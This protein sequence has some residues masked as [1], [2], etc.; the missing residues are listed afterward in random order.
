LSAKISNRIEILL[1]HRDSQRVFAE[2]H[3]VFYFLNPAKSQSRKENSPQFVRLSEVEAPFAESLCGA[4]TSLSLTA[5]SK[6]CASATL[7]DYFATITKTYVNLCGKTP[8]K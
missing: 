3:R 7:R 8:L 6:L 2:I 1:L 4:S 5:A